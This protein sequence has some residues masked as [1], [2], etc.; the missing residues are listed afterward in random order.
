MTV[1]FTINDKS[2][3]DTILPFELYPPLPLY[4]VEF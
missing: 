4:N 1:Y 2:S 3:A